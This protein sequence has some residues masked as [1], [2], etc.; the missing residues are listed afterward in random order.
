MAHNHLRMQFLAPLP[1]RTWELWDGLNEH[2]NILTVEEPGFLRYAALDWSAR[3]LAID[4]D[5]DQAVLLMT[6]AGYL[7]RAYEFLVTTVGLANLAWFTSPLIKLDLEGAIRIAFLKVSGHDLPADIADRWP[8]CDERS[9]VFVL[10]RA[11]IARTT[12]MTENT[13]ASNVLRQCIDPD[14]ARRY[15]SL[16]NM[17]AACHAAGGR[18]IPPVGS[19]PPR[20]RW[21]AIETGI[22]LLAVDRVKNAYECFEVVTAH[23]SYER[24]DV[25]REVAGELAQ[26]AA[27]LLNIPAPTLPSPPPPAPPVAWSEARVA[28]K[29]L[30]RELDFT[31][32]LAIYK[33][34]ELVDVSDIAEHA[35]AR[36]RCRLALGDADAAVGLVRAVLARDPSRHEARAIEVRALL[37][38]KLHTDAITAVDAWIA[39]SPDDCNAHYARGKALLGL[40]R[41]VEARDAFERACVL[42][43]KLVEAMWL[44]AAVDKSLARLRVTVG[45]PVPMASDLPPGELREALISGRLEDGIRL[46]RDDA[47][48]AAQLRLGDLLLYAGRFEEAIGV[49]ERI[50]DPAALARQGTRADRSRSHRRGARDPRD[51]R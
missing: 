26:H 5:S 20:L 43:P 49:F 8:H 19:R 16:Y 31:R 1:S 9:L 23:R 10:G 12:G 37:A 32:A 36:A 17:R 46:L 15:P 25:L 14:P 45:T 48:S 22:G 44:R 41:L 39:A 2:P 30:E 21:N 6:H 4:E 24:I 13:P 38:V 47:T 50:D 28:G 18:G 3:R 42:S 27:S 34:A 7:I 33:R 35:I 40:R 29:Q 11:L 51:D